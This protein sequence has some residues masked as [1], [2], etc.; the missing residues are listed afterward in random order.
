MLS[1]SRRSLASSSALTYASSM[2]GVAVAEMS[3]LPSA[4]TCSLSS[5]R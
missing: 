2:L 1:A 4:N 5:V 3:Y